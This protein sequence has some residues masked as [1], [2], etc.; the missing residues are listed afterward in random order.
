MLMCRLAL[1]L[2]CARLAGCGL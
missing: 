2:G 1:V